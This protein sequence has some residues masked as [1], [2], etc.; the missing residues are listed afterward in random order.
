MTYPRLGFCVRAKE[1]FV[2]TKGGNISAA[3]VARSFV[4]SLSHSHFILAAASPFIPRRKKLGRA[5]GND[6]LDVN[7]REMK[8]EI[9]QMRLVSCHKDKAFT[10]S[11]SFCLEQWW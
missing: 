2:R 9:Y 5:L 10:I 4:R 1:V 7:D 8:K 11:S 3:D 6:G